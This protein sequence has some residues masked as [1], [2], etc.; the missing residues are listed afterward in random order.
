MNISSRRKKQMSFSGQENGETRVILLM[1]YVSGVVMSPS[2]E[3]GTLTLCMLGKFSC[4]CCHLLTLFQR[5]LSGALSNGLD[6]DQDR[7][8]VGPDLGLNC[9]KRLSADDKSSH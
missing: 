5:I 6:P 3:Q 9:L 7:H 4:F 2:N 1:P 8:S